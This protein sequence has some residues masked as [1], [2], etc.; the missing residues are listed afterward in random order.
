[1]IQAVKGMDA[2]VYMAMGSLNYDEWTGT[3][4]SFDVNVKGIHFALK[5]AKGRYSS[6]CVYQQHVRV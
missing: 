1:M 5:A 3:E 2:V 4:S 6:S